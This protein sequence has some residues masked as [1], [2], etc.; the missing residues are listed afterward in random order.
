METVESNDRVKQKVVYTGEY[1][2]TDLLKEQEQKYKIC[3]VLIPVIMAALFI[4]MGLLNND[5]SRVFYV[6]MPYVLQFLP[7]AYMIISAVSF[8]P[9]N[10]LT[11]AQ[12]DKTYMRI[13]TSGT[14]I[15][16]LALASILGEIL[17]IVRGYGNTLELEIIFLVCNIIISI[18]AFITLRIHAKIKFKMVQNDK[19]P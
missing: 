10:M 14:W 18:L 13:R 1:Y 19:T 15:L 9:K 2:K 7:I 6:V 11:V 8:F 16:I 3:L 17:Y 12:Y 4:Y 5:G